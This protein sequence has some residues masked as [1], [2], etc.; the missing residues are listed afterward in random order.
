[1]IVYHTTLQENVESILLN[2]LDPS[3]MKSSWHQAEFE[4]ARLTN[5]NLKLEDQPRFCYASNFDFAFWWSLKIKNSV[6]LK[7]EIPNEL[8]NEYVFNELGEFIRF[9]VC[10]PSKF[11]SL[12]P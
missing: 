12:T 3:R 11:I 1:M 6:I 9:H 8:I 4:N 10:V 7:I 2:G 5:P